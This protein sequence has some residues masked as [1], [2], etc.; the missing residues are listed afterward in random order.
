MIAITC[1]LLLALTWRAAA[2]CGPLDSAAE[3]RAPL[4]LSEALL[5]LSAV[6]PG[7]LVRVVFDEDLGDDSNA[8]ARAAGP[9]DLAFSFKPSASAA[10]TLAVAAKSDSAVDV[11][12]DKLPGAPRLR[13]RCASPRSLAAVFGCVSLTLFLPC[14]QRWAMRVARA[15]AVTIREV[16]TMSMETETEAVRTQLVRTAKQTLQGLWFCFNFFLIFVFFEMVFNDQ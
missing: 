14:F 7:A 2:L 3:L 6:R 5:D 12:Q 10:A 9:A 4:P 13:S 11:P 15:P 16:P 1:A 8:Y